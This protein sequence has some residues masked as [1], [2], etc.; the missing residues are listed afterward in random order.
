[1]CGTMKEGF[2]PMK[3]RTWGYLLGEAFTSIR[4]NGLM[5]LASFTT[6]GLSLLVLGV[7][8]LLVVNLNHM[9]RSVEAQL[10][11]VA[12]LEKELNQGELASLKSQVETIPGVVMVN[13]V[14]RD[15]A[16][17]RLRERLPDQTRVF[18]TVEEMNPL[19]PSLEVQVEKSDRIS[20]VAEVLGQMTMVEE[21]SYGREV[22]EKL[23]KITRI[24][25]AGGLA[26]VGFLALATLLII[27]NSV[28]L[29][30]HA[31]RREIAVMKL[32]G[33]TDSL[34]R[35]PF[36]LEGT[37]LGLAGGMGTAL[38]LWKGYLMLVERL[39]QVLPF[40]PVVTGNDVLTQ[41]C[42]LLVATGAFIGAAGSALSVRRYLRV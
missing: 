39:H 1:M 41:V 23:S 31:R 20:E 9:V 22:V 26:L 19:R 2:T 25:N 5:S 7:T 40:L 34:I 16:L 11:I 10:E 33:A 17:D 3:L 37:I 18:D 27:S 24:L 6:A 14:S 28:R 32:V 36:I 35:W 30:V 29:T 38:L 4:K 42:L 15:E 12:Y 13:Y 8:L 21:V